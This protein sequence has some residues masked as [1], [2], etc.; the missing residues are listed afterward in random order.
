MFASSTITE[1]DV[2]ELI[3][4]V[5]MVLQLHMVQDAA[6]DQS[7]KDDFN[8]FDDSYFFE[9]DPNSTPEEIETRKSVYAPRHRR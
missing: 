3:L 5:A 7:K 2:D 1:P 4:S 8:C 6:G 9:L